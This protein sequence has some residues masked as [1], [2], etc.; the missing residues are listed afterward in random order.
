MGLR[1][2]RILEADE[3]GIGAA[4]GEENYERWNESRAEAIAH[5]SRPSIQVQTVTA[6]ASG[7]GAAGLNLVGVKIESVQR[8]GADRPGGRRFGALVHA[9]LAT[10]EPDATPD[11]ITAAAHANGRLVDATRDEIG[12]AVTAVRGALGHPLMRR[13]AVSASA[14]SLRRETPVQLRREDGTLVEGVVDLAFR[15]QTPDFAGWTVVD[16][17]TDREIERSQAQYAAQV[18]AYV[19]AILIFNLLK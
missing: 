3:R 4:R 13:A 11:E 9:V 7:I 19:E 2:Q 1:Q 12:A 6:L 10:V 15:E 18:A 14:G 16:F 8:V 17:K 5:A